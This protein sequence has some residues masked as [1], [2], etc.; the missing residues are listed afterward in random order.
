MHLQAFQHLGILQLPKLKRAHT[1]TS[2]SLQLPLQA[3]L[4]S[5]SKQREVVC[6]TTNNIHIH[7]FDY[8]LI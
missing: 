5:G 2:A 3:P 7:Y 4:S 1:L 6:L 8:Y